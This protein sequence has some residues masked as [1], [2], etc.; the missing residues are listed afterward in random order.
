MFGHTKGTPLEI[1]Q[2]KIKLNTTISHVHQVRYQL[3][4]NYVTIVKH[5]INKL[6]VVGFIK[7][8]E[9]ATWLLPI[10]VVF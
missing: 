6:L 8:V 9:E 5:D 4:L 2:H 10:M 3:N 1:V 7:S